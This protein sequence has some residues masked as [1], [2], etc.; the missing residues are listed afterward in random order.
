VRL[1]VSFET[2][3]PKC[4]DGR[5]AAGL[6]ETDQNHRFNCY[7]AIPPYSWRTANGEIG[8]ASDQGHGKT[9][10]VPF[11]PLARSF[12]SRPFGANYGP[13][14]ARWCLEPDRASLNLRP[15]VRN[16][17]AGLM[18]PAFKNDLRTGRK[19]GGKIA[20]M[21]QDQA[22]VRQGC[23]DGGCTANPGGCSIIMPATAYV[24]RP[25]SISKSVVF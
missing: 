8:S 16:A 13:A 7:P 6:P 10:A 23:S 4:F 20:V 24:L 14:C 25:R 18:G 3:P 15:Q 21:A 5:K 1:L 9:A 12:S 17:H 11:S 19:F 22:L 2:F